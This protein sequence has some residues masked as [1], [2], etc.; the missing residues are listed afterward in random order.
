MLNTVIL[1]RNM[2]TR[3]NITKL[4]KIK[5]GR[6]EKIPTITQTLVNSMGEN[7]GVFYFWLKMCA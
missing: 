6:G 2:K 1:N 4:K 5:S 3:L 7:V